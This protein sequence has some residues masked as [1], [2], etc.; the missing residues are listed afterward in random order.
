VLKT[1]CLITCLAVFVCTGEDPA[2]QNKPS[3]SIAQQLLKQHNRVQ[4]EN[5]RLKG[6]LH[7][8]KK[9]ESENRYRLEEFQQ[10]VSILKISSG[11]MND[12]D[13]KEFEKK[14]V[15]DTEEKTAAYFDH[16]L[17]P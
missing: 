6:E 15:E 12:K 1:C 7:E 3:G 11:E 9:K 17:Y 8:M 16:P 5:E 2:P 10:Q 14:M 13:K 4:K